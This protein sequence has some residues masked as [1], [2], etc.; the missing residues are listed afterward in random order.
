MSE[1]V[2]PAPS[3]SGQLLLVAGFVLTGTVTTLL[4]PLLPIL[5]AQWSLSDA[6]SGT[7]FVAQFA[8]S[9]LAAL[10]AGFLAQRIGMKLTLAGGFLL[11]GTGLGTLFGSGP[12]MSHI[13]IAGYGLGLGFTIP[14]INL[15][16]A[17]MQRPRSAAA[18]N[19][20]N[21]L[22][23]AGALASPLLVS[24]AVQVGRLQMMLLMVASIAFAIALSMAFVRFG[25]SYVQIP[26]T[27]SATEAPARAGRWLTFAL[28]FFLYVGLENSLAGWA[29]AYAQRTGVAHSFAS[30]ALVPA[31][32][33]ASL[34]VGRALFSI[35]M[36]SLIT[37]AATAFLGSVMVAL[38]C[39]LMIVGGSPALVIGGVSV[40]GF[41]LA[42]IFPNAIA[43]ARV[44]FSERN[45]TPLFACA[46][47]GGATIPYFIGVASTLTGRM[48]NGIWLVLMLAAALAALQLRL[49]RGTVS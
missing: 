19:L 42:P 41:G 36:M 48:S 24:L 23:T 20:L 4:G 17:D 26:D 37:P 46:G 29:A 6:R 28:V 25:G 16:V 2:R 32:F 39:A 35:L 1:N 38:G 34:L 7:F 40:A 47:L 3:V 43:F 9:T 14:N 49:P 8:G 30:A 31:A 27:R 44:W 45:I 13:A 21:M 15:V 22:W 5:A 12:T 11:M 18:L 10:S 33:W